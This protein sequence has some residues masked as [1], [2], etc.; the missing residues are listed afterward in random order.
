M[1]IFLLKYVSWM[2]LDKLTMWWLDEQQFVPFNLIICSVIFFPA[3][4]IL[5]I[6]TSLIFRIRR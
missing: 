5:M 3:I 6:N 4:I 1:K 2:S